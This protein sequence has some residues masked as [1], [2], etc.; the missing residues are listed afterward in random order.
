MYILDRRHWKVRLFQIACLLGVLST[1]SYAANGMYKGSA[2]LV[3]K[4]EKVSEFKKAVHK[5]IGPTRKEPANI[6]YEAFQVIDEKGN[7]TNRFEFHE[8]WASEKA[9]MIDHKENSPHMKEF[10]A[11]IG[12]GTE[13]SWVEFFEVGGKTVRELK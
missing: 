4:P 9:M 13:H 12:I 3:I 11:L 2:T 5:I 6:S 10:F 8:L 1:Q 7:E